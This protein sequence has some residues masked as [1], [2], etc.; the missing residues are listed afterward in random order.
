MRGIVSR[1]RRAAAA[2]LLIVVLLA[3]S[4]L[5]SDVPVDVSLWD[6]FVAW[7]YGES[8][9]TAGADQDAFTIWLMGRIGIPGG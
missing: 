3:P 2:W 1:G 6:A 8:G 9:S 5:A 4:A 7:L